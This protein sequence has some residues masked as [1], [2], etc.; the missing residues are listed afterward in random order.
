MRP[1]LGGT[2]GGPQETLRPK[3]NTFAN[4]DLA[5]AHY[6]EAKTLA[7]DRLLAFLL[8]AWLLACLSACLAACLLACCQAACLPAWRL[9]ACWVGQGEHVFIAPQKTNVTHS[10]NCWNLAGVGCQWQATYL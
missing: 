3:R 7:G 6:P 9:V 4:L 1:A 8:G 10:G 2:L 5:L